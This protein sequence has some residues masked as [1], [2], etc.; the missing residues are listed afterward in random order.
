MKAIRI[1]LI[2]ITFFTLCAQAQT[3]KEELPEPGTIT[4]EDYEA[5]K[6]KISQYQGAETTA[7]DPSVVQISID[8]EYTVCFIP[9]ESHP[10]YPG[11]ACRS[12]GIVEGDIKVE[13]V[14]WTADPNNVEFQPWLNLFVVQDQEIRSEIIESTRSNN[15]EDA[16]EESQDESET[17]E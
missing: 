13:T 10:A 5:L 17:T 6:T 1:L 4:K 12:V 3:L 8:S 16:T 11:I 15:D 9:V 14:G 2:L 7:Q